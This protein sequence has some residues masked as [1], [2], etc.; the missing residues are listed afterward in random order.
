ME[1]KFEHIILI[2]SQKLS[3]VYQMKLC[4]SSFIETE[5]GTIKT[6]LHVA[7]SEITEQK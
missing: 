2:Y 1:Q 4:K 5:A 3:L 6:A 7:H